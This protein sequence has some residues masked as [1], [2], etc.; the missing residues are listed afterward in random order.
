MAPADDGDAIGIAN[1]AGGAT[2]THGAADTLTDNSAI[3]KDGLAALRKSGSSAKA[4]DSLPA[5]C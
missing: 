2:W 5:A 4:H 3:Q 1:G